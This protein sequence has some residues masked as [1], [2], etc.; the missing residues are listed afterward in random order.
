MPD[1]NYLID[2]YLKARYE[3]DEEEE[4]EEYDED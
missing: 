4:D 2:S 3:E 1:V